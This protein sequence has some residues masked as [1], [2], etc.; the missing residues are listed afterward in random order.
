M[1][2]LRGTI[3]ALVGAA[4]AGVALSLRRESQRRGVSAVELLGDVP[5]L[6]HDDVQ[7]VVKAAEGALRDGQRAAHAAETHISEVLSRPRQTGEAS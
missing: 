5:E 1:S 3:G 2:M 7:R 6:V 4:V